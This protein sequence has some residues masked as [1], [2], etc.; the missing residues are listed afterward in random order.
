VVEAVA[1]LQNVSAAQDL[2]S[3]PTQQVELSDAPLQQPSHAQAADFVRA[4]AT[5]PIHEVNAVPAQAPSGWT[6]GVANQIDSLASHLK[7]LDAHHTSVDPSS[8]SSR[9]PELNGKDV[10][11]DA[12]AQMERAYMLA[13]EA[14][15][16]SRGSTEATKIFNTLLKG[17]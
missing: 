12:V 2:Q 5:L 13:I 10:M 3:L 1:G 15:M 8:G 16:A 7:V 4:A 11:A 9:S 6:G 14:T 17:Q